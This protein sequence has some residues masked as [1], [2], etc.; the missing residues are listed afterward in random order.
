MKKRVLMVLSLVILSVVLITQA[1]ADVL[2]EG[3]WSMTMNTKMDSMPPEMAAAMK[4]ME[5]LPPEQR[6]MMEKMQERMGV[7]MSANGQ[8]MTITTTQ[9]ITKKNPVPNHVK[10][11]EYCKQT[12]DFNG[13]TV[14]FHTT[15]DHNDFKVDASGHMTYTGDTMQGEIKSHEVKN[16]RSMDSTIEITGQ[17]LGACSL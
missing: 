9:C 17:Y 2:K 1:K 15:C 13:N 14:N 5:N 12:H 11:P 6:A 10:T 3:K 8:G 7:S 4:Q 16:G